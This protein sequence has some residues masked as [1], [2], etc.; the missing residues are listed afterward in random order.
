MRKNVPALKRLK[1]LVLAV[2]IKIGDDGTELIELTWIPSPV[3]RESKSLMFLNKGG[4][5]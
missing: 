1:K 4:R 3:E 5:S 2:L